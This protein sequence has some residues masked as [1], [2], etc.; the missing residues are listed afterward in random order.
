MRL[1]ALIAVA[2]ILGPFL[3]IVVDRAAGRL[4]VQFEHRC[5]SCQAGQG[6][7][8]MIPVLTWFRSCGRC[9]R[10][11]GV[12]YPA[13]DLMLVASFVLLGRRFDDPR[14]LMPYLLLSAV[15]VTLSVIDAE[16]HLLPN[17]VVWPSILA[18]LFLVLV[19]SGELGYEQGIYSALFGAGLLGGT[20]GLLHVAYEPGMGR[21]DVKLALLLG[22]FVGWIEP[23]LIGT[24]QRILYVMLLAFGGAGVVG[25]AYNMIRRRKGE[26]PFGPALAVA[27]ML[28]VLVSPGL[29]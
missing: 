28:V 22:L 11:K 19:V 7:S 10:H 25:L 2:L 12:R 13:V 8:S 20:L 14:V 29:I 26:I 21:G 24:V 6:T 9:G 27:T 15:L 17:N 5:V 16:T 1:L 4:R 3:G 18:G 23:G